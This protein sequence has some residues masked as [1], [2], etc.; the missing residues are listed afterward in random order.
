MKTRGAIGDSATISAPTPKINAA[1]ND[2]DRCEASSDAWVAK[3]T[4]P[5]VGAAVT[6]V[7]STFI[8]GS[9]ADSAY[10]VSTDK[11]GNVYATGSTDSSNFPTVNPLQGKVAFA[12]VFISTLKSDGSALTFSTYLGGSSYDDQGNGI[13]VDPSGNLYVTGW[14]Q[15][16]RF[17]LVNPIQ[18]TYGGG[19]NDAVTSV[20]VDT[21]GNLYVAGRFRGTANFGET[22][23]TSSAPDISAAARPTS[24]SPSPATPTTPT[25][26]PTVC[27][28]P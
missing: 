27:R 13:A 14:T 15:S 9:G 17:P 25:T 18:A 12:D 16:T 24:G 11:D 3:F 28:W 23:L 20:A 1:I 5:D 6:L 4:N 21:K 2:V 26:S 19:D 22:N 10:G 7:W 8:G